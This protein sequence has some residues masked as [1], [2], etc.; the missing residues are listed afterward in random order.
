MINVMD[1][2]LPIDAVRSGIGEHVLNS[3][4][5]SSSVGGSLAGRAEPLWP[6]A[7]GGKT[8]IGF[9]F[10]KSFRAPGFRVNLSKRGVG[11]S[12]GGKGLT[13]SVGPSGTRGT[14]SIPRTMTFN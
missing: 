4:T 8:T 5:R 10:R 6:S 1:R 9:G 14:A 12:V 2:L 3:W 13:A 7:R 11:V